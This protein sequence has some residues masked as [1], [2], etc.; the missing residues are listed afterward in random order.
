MSKNITYLFVSLPTS[1]SP[2]N[3]VDEARTALQSAITF[4]YGRVF[5][6]TI[7]EFKIGSLDTLVHQADELAKLANGCES[8]VGRVADMLRG[9]L[10]GDEDK[11]SQ[12]KSVNDSQSTALSSRP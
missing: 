7:P 9:V 12:N 4:D 8:V 10:D 2:A 5:P 6:F 1:I 11:I 3:D